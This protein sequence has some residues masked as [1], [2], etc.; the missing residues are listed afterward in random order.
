MICQRNSQVKYNDKILYDFIKD[1]TNP[2]SSN[3]LEDTIFVIYGDHGNALY[4]GAY[5]SLLGR[6][7][8]DLEYR[9]LLLNIPIIIYDPT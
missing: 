4:K 9:R 6:E 7:L 5:E 3:Y 1:V 8:E 2:E